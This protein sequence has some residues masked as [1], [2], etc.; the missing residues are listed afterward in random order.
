MKN[1]LSLVLIV[2]AFSCKQTVKESKPVV[3]IADTTDSYSFSN[4]MAYEDPSAAETYDTSATTM[5]VSHTKVGSLSTIN[6]KSTFISSTFAIE[7]Y[8]V[9]VKTGWRQG[10][11]VLWLNNDKQILDTCYTVWDSRRR[12]EINDN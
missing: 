11:T 2:L 5:L 3:A 6:K 7:G 1:L 12:N 9:V 4:S 10:M 8:E